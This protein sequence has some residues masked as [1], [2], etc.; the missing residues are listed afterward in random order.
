MTYTFALDVIKI[1]SFASVLLCNVDVRIGIDA[2]PMILCQGKLL[3]FWKGLI[4]F[5]SS[6]VISD[7]IPSRAPVSRGRK[8]SIFFFANVEEKKN[9]SFFLAS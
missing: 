5:F 8:F 9:H 3:T 4:D 2:L 1:L 7:R 6:V